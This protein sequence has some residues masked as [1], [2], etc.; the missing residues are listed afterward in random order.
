V[1][2]RTVNSGVALKHTTCAAP[3][4]PASG[5]LARRFWGDA[6]VDCL[7]ATSSRDQS[8]PK[9]MARHPTLRRETA[10]APAKMPRRLCILGVMTR[11]E[12]QRLRM[13]HTTTSAPGALARR[14]WGNASVNGMSAT[15]SRQHSTVTN[16]ARHR[17]LPRAM[18]SASAKMP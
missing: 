12:V 18:P 9:R 14:F 16:M 6:S 5:A 1:V 13:R 10:S 2:L 8:P 15:S 3:P 17:T 4:M 7:P 11:Q